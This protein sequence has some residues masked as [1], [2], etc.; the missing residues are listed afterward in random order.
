MDTKTEKINTSH[1]QDV[2]KSKSSNPTRPL[3]KKIKCSEALICI[4]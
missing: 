2:T 1:E 3:L 4:P